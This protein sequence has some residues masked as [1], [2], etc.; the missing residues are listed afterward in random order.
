MSKLIF[1]RDFTVRVKGEDV[2]IKKGINKIEP[3]SSV[4]RWLK[5]GCELYSDKEEAD[6]KAKADAE[7]KSKIEAE[8]KAKAEAEEKEKSDAEAKKKSDEEKAKSDS[9]SKK[10]SGK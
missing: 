2:I 8:E 7:E 1:H 10:K 6:A 4:K 9:D 3:E 5:R